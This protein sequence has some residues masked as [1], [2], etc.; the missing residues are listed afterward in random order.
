MRRAHYLKKNSKVELPIHMIFVDTETKGV[1]QN[2]KL[3]HHYLWF[4]WACHLRMRREGDKDYSREEWFRF[5]KAEHFWEWVC[6]KSLDRTRTWIFAHNWNYDAGVLDVSQWLSRF[7]FELVTYINDKPPFIVEFRGRNRTLRL[8]DTLNYF[9]GSLASIGESI[10]IPKMPMPELQSTKRVWD[11]YCKRDVGVIRAAI[12]GFRS[13]V[14]EEQLGNFQMTLASQAMCAYRHRFMDKQILIHD[15]AEVCQLEREGYYGGRSECFFLGSVNEPVY[16][17]DIN[18]MYPSIMAACS[19]PT[20]LIK[21]RRRMD[22]ETL[23]EWLETHAVMAT[24]DIDTD[25]P[26]YPTRFNHRLVFPVGRFTTTLATPE[27]REALERG[28][29]LSIGEVAIYEQAILFSSFVNTL[30]KLRQTYKRDGNTTYSYMVKILMNS[31]YGKFGQNGSKW[32]DVGITDNPFDGVQLLQETP[33]SEIHKYRCRLG[34]LQEYRRDGESDNSFPAIAATITSYARLLLWKLIEQAGRENVYYT[35][36]D[37]LICNARGYN[38]L[39]HVLDSNTLGKLKV[40]DTA[41][42]AIFYGAKDYHFGKIEKHKG[43]KKSATR[44]G[45]NVWEQDRFYSWDYQISRGLDGYIP[46]ERVRRTLHRVYQKGTPTPSGWVQ[47]YV[48]GL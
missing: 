22:I 29:I 1:K 11:T 20:K 35:D 16:Y 13:L 10:G 34:M 6:S 8:I 30:Y 12:L 9:A 27:L 48:F 7:G 2:D 46:I 36:T 42:S 18:S 39:S 38:N 26:L 24:V 3:E 44:I 25:T 17:L 5:S 45:D 21:S 41:D 47:P 43:I 31:L 19:V 4:G 14:E 28:H 15:D 37:S 23:Q 33:Q 40:E 32:Y